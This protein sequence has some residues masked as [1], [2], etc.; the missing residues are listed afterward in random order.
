VNDSP[1][2]APL[3]NLLTKGLMHVLS[4]P[5][6]IE[7]FGFGFLVCLRYGGNISKGMHR[8]S[9]ADDSAASTTHKRFGYAADHVAL[10]L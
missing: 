6:V 2:K 8:V 7:T 4:L 1:R 9:R 10:N 3:N 5:R